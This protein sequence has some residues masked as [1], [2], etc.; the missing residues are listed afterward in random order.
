MFGGS[1]KKEEGS[2]K[3]ISLAVVKRN[4]EKLF[5]IFLLVKKSS[6][7]PESEQGPLSRSQRAFT[8]DTSTHNFISHEVT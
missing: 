8:M 6:V 7:P 2:L 4:R 5:R 3:K 1:Q